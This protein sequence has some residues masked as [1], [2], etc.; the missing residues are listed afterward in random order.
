MLH[1]KAMSDSG[2]GN[3]DAMALFR[4]DAE[5]HCRASGEDGDEP[6]RMLA[7]GRVAAAGRAVVRRCLG[8]LP[9]REPH[10]LLPQHPPCSGLR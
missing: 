4:S 10:L 3:P 7:G 2:G 6:S 8:L 1:Y 5:K 9:Q